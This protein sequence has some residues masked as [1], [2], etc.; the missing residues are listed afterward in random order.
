MEFRGLTGGGR[1]PAILLHVCGSLLD[2]VQ[3]SSSVAPAHP[4]RSS[5]AP[6]KRSK[7]PR[8]APRGALQPLQPSCFLT[9]CTNACP[10]T[11]A[12]LRR[13][14]GGLETRVCPAVPRFALRGVPHSASPG[15]RA[16]RA[17]APVGAAHRSHTSPA[18]AGRC[19]SRT[20]TSPAAPALSAAPLPA[21]APA[22]RRDR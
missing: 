9:H 15:Y 11:T 7:S 10:K 22:P 21:P 8:T 17:H 16:P 5:G 14:T 6:R 20:P 4:Q 1:A 3:R 12:N 13:R 18:P 2:S 19:S